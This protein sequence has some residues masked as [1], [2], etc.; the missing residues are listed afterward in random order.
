MDNPSNGC[1]NISGRSRRRR[2]R[3]CSKSLSEPAARRRDAGNEHG[4]RGIAPRH[5]R[6]RAASSPHR[7]CCANVLRA[8][9]TVPDR[10]RADHKRIGRIARVSL[11][12]I[13]AWIGRDLIPAEA[14]ALGE[15]INRA[16]LAD[17]RSGPINWSARCTSAPSGASKTPSPKSASDER[18]AAG[19]PSRSARRERWKISSTMIAL[20]SL[21]DVLADFARRLPNHIRTF[22]RDPDRCR[23]KQIDTAT[24]QSPPRPAGCARRNFSYTASF[25]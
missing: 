15:D 8:A 23:D 22:E 14:K 9:R 16:L 25:W 5:S 2:G 1:G 11:E 10:R 7:R 21:R 19:S 6:R 3:C 18:R 13:W 24:A 17:D 20:L 12:P 4:A